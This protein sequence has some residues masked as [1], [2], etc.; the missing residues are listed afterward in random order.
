MKSNIPALSKKT[1][2]KLLDSD[3]RKKIIMSY[4]RKDR[5]GIFPYAKYLCDA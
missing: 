1:M 3:F 5:Y 2:T 4:D